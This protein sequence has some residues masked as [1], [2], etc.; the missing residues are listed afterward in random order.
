[1]VTCWP[2]TP[3]KSTGKQDDGVLSSL[4]LLLLLLVAA[5]MVAVSVERLLWV[6]F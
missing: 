6:S 2:S 3:T 1:M 4:L 5:V